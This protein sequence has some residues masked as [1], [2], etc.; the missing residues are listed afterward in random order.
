MEYRV[1]GKTGLEVSVV[2]IGGWPLGGLIGGP[3]GDPRNPVV[4]EGWSG[5]VDE[6][7]VKMIRRAEELGVNLLDTAEIYGDGHSESIIGIATKGRRDRFIISTKV[8]GFYADVPD[9][10][11]TRR[12]IVEACEG[13]LRRLQTDYIDV[14]LLHKLPHEGAVP[15]AMETLT[16]LKKEG[17]I[18]WSGV[19]YSAA[20]KP[21][22]L[23]GLL[24]LGEVAAMVVG[25]NMMNRGA[26]ATTLRLAKEQNI[27]TMIASPLA[28]G[29][30]S[31]QWFD[32]PPEFDLSDLRYHGY[33]DRKATAAAFKKLSELRFL[34][35]GGERTM[36]QAA[37]RFILD[38]EGVTSVIPGAL[39]PSEIEENAGT[40]DVPPLTDEERSRAIAIA[41]EARRAW[42]R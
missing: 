40:S 32:N 14:Y 31:G 13:S 35:E 29:A 39:R 10:E 9:E 26:E 28:S 17:K 1:L 30:L 23:R 37:L 11:H 25:F 16:Q 41:D 4:D 19:S 22:E 7:S 12:R 36:T 42:G 6:E 38:T 33:A 8:R 2:G 15:A 27:G 34:T 18:R 20:S 3:V 21:D 24:E 5:A